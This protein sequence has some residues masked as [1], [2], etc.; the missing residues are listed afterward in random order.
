MEVRLRPRWI[1][2]CGL[3]AAVIV[4]AA[5]LS[6]AA[7][8]DRASAAAAADAPGFAVASCTRFG[9]AGTAASDLRALAWALRVPTG[10]L[11][12]ELSRGRT[13]A[14]IVEARGLSAPGVVDAIVRRQR[15]ELDRRVA[16]G[17]MHPKQEAATLADLRARLERAIAGDVP[18]GPGCP[19]RP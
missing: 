18:A 19:V 14:G 13:L 11:V 8:S 6:G 5:L 2:A 15:A 12:W 16:G 9:G 17:G 3:L 10:Q 7:R 4:A 1:C